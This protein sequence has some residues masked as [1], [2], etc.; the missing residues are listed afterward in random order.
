MCIHKYF[1]ICTT[2][3]WPG[4]YYYYFSVCKSTNNN[5][6]LPTLQYKL[7]NSTPISNNTTIENS[8]MSL[9]DFLVMFMNSLFVFMMMIYS[10]YMLTMSFKANEIKLKNRMKYYEKKSNDITCIPIDKPFIIRLSGK[11]F[12]S[13]TKRYRK[14]A[15]QNS[16]LPYSKEFKHSMMLTANDLLNQFM[17][18]SVYTYFDQIILIMNM[19]EK[20]KTNKFGGS[21]QEMLSVISSYASTVFMCHFSEELLKCGIN[22][23]KEMNENDSVIDITIKTQYLEKEKELITK[24]TKTNKINSIP[25]FDAKIVV[26]PKN[27]EYEIV[28]YLIFHSG[29]CTDKF[30]TIYAETYLGDKEIRKK[31]NDKRIDL[32]KNMGHDLNSDEIDNVIKHGVF[33]KKPNKKDTEFHIFTKLVFSDDLCDFLTNGKYCYVLKNNNGEFQQIIRSKY[34][35]FDLFDL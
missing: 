1:K 26:F 31:S 14:L 2:Y 28:N 24:L 30:I 7:S 15:K 9:Y 12:R 32:L 16:D 3:F 5:K 35:C 10:M 11:K 13:L 25:T 34:N 29:N 27:K 33:L 4:C 21:I 6:L 22:F 19:K 23:G 8:Y 20:N 18:S 17:C